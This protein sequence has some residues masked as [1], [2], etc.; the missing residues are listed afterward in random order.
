M[1]KII[2]FPTKM[3]SSIEPP[4]VAVASDYT[5]VEG[6]VRSI[7]IVKQALFFLRHAGTEK[8]IKLTDKGF[9]GRSFVQAFWDEHLSTPQYLR[10]R[11]TRELDCPEV[12]RIHILL[13]ESKYVRKFKGAIQLTMKGRTALES[14]SCVDVYRDLFEVG[15][16]RWNWACQDRFPDFHFI[17]ESASHLLECLLRWPTDTITAKALF[18]SVFGET[19]ASAPESESEDE[20]LDSFYDLDYQMISCLRI[21]FFE[22]FCVPFGILLDQSADNF[23]GKSTDPFEKT[24]FFTCDFSDVLS[25]S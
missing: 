15:M 10:F 11:P 18:E 17:Q 7:P 13:T 3:R 20:S 21:R 19:K 2:A 9:L 5:S 12:T 22:R 24:E 8:G 1:A 6:R 4:A 14:D 16:F 23:F 25:D